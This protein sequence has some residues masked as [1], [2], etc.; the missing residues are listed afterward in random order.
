[1]EADMIRGKLTQKGL[2]VTPQRMAI[3]EAVFSLNNHPTA[4]NILDFVRNRI[5]SVATGT[6]YNILETLVT[7]KI[8][9][10]VKT[11][12]D[13]MRYDGVSEQHHHL[14]CSECDLIEDYFDDELDRILKNYFKDKDIPGF[15]LDNIVLQI[16][17]TFNKC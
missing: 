15:N 8:I 17:G 2:K 7:K 11:D 16:R 3:L 1:M 6:V 14:Y 9:S 12:H 4:E 13:V 10:R 5:P